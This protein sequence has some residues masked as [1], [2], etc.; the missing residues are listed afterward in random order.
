MSSQ[1]E[2]FV[3][4]VH[5]LIPHDPLTALVLA[6][7]SATQFDGLA[8]LHPARVVNVGIREQLM[9]GVAAGLA[10]EGLRPIVHT[11][12]PFL[13]E[14]ACEQLKLDLVHQGLGAVLVSVGASYDWAAG[15][16]T[17]HAPADVA[18]VG[19]WP[20][21]TVVVPGHADDVTA[22]LDGAARR[23]DLTYVRLS[24]AE[25]RTG[26]DGPAGAVVRLRAGRRGTVLVVGPLRDAVL[27]ATADLDLTVLHTIT[28][29]PLDRASLVALAAEA[30]DVAIVE[31][32]LEGT[33]TAL[34]AEALASRPRRFLSVGVPRDTPERYGTREAHDAAHGLDARG[35]RGRLEALG[36]S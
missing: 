10:L 17:H 11:Y 29:R 36:R 13:V 26:F 12:A 18:L 32:Y 14:R 28:P 34:V 4:H 22:A 5:E 24:L 20:G 21:V 30:T 27:E 33:S 19:A 3:A 23:T 9:V 1:R 6:D 16:R 15:G 25:N 35:L 31:P 2:R 8:A 7:I